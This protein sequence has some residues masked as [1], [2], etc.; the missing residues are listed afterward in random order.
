MKNLRL[1]LAPHPDLAVEPIIA[2]SFDHA[3]KDPDPTGVEIYPWHRIVVIEGLYSFLSIGVWKE[4]GEILDERWLTTV[5]FD[6]ATERIIDRH[7]TSGVAGSI[8]VTLGNSPLQAHCSQNVQEAQWRA[9]ENDMP[10]ESDM[11]PPR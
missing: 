8:E 2:P 3:V 5:E 11:F 6:K 9:R 10:S 1:P 4:A 7:I